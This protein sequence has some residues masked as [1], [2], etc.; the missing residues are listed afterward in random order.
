MLPT[1]AMLAATTPMLGC[2]ASLRHGVRTTDAAVQLQQ[3]TRSSSNELD[4]AV[5]PDARSIAYERADSLSSKP[6]V[7]VMPM[8]ELG[9]VQPHLEYSSNDAM[10]ATPTW[11]RD[12]SSLVF[13]SD[14]LGS[15]RLVQTIGAAIAQTRFLGPAGEGEIQA[16]WPSVSGEGRLAFS[17]GTTL[18]F[19]TGWQSSRSYDDGIGL[20]DLAGSGMTVIPGTEPA[21]SPDGKQLAFAR[22]ADGHM[23]VFVAK[24]DGSGASQITDGSEDDREPAWSPD[25][26]QIAFCSMRRGDAGWEANLFV[27]H[28]DGSDRIQ[29][30]EGDALACR[31]DW[32]SD[33]FI[34]F[35]ANTRER[36]HI[37]RLKPS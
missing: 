9:S 35:H 10:G 12:G 36:F 4:P 32:A 16:A 29:L 13:E 23:H 8:T 18:L 22:E 31:P 28:A 24:P 30:T 14:A 19:R 1:F 2:S 7:E 27:V 17:L 26:R 15:P 3:V 34:Y 20:S 11:T 21:W 25:G 33:G 5:S 6:H 37:W